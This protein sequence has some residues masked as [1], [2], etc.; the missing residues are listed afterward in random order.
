MWQST[1]HAL[2]EGSARNLRPIPH[3]PELVVYVLNLSFQIMEKVTSVSLTDLQSH[4]EALGS[5]EM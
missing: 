4:L 3:P 5:F 2:Q 1:A